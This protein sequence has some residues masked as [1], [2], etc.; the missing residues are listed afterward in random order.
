[1]RVLAIADPHLS[2]RDPKPMDIFGP[3]WEGH[4]EAFFEGWR[5]VVREDDLVLVPG[6]LS[7]AMRLEH[8]LSD[9]HDIAALPGTKVLLRGNHDYWWPSI[10]KLRAALPAS[11]HAVQNDAL[12]F[13]SVIVAGTRGWTCPGSHEFDEHDAKVYRRELSR[14]DL[15]LARATALRRPGDRTVV[16]LHFP[17][18]N[19]RLEPSGFTERIRAFAPDALV[20]GHVHGGREQVLSR[21]GDVGV[22]FVAA[23]ALAFEPKTVLDGV[24]DGAAPSEAR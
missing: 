19:P 10:G 1:M 14:L 8:A 16:M 7:W 12:R 13:G 17:P 22:H 3:G 11:M 21:L 6:D 18:T 23:D 2:R 24:P 20:F 4:P 5:R 15:S 9:L